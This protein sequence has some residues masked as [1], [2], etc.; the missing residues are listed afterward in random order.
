MDDP[1][2]ETQ[3]GLALHGEKLH[4]MRAVANWRHPKVVAVAVDVPE[5][6][7]RPIEVTLRTGRLRATVALA[8]TST[9]ESVYRRLTS[10]AD[11]L[12]ETHKRIT[13]RLRPIDE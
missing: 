2:A 8:M 5:P 1:I 4:V 6:L 3:G 9:R 11:E 10:V 12:S 7:D 13:Y